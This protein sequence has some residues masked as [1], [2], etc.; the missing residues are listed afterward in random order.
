MKTQRPMSSDYNNQR[1]ECSKK[2]RQQETRRIMLFPYFTET[3]SYIFYTTRTPQKLQTYGKICGQ[4]YCALCSC[5]E[6]IFGEQSQSLRCW[7]W[8]AINFFFATASCWFFQL[9]LLQWHLKEHITSCPSKMITI[10]NN[11]FSFALTFRGKK[12]DENIHSCEKEE[13]EK[14]LR[15]R[16]S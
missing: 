3:Q 2:P 5:S 10:N 13:G 1:T 7:Y 6:Y 14:K 8:C 9:S 15:F 12:S 4:N 16:D 11:C